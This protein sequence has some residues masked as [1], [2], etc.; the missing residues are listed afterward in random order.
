VSSA[1]LHVSYG[2]Q[3]HKVYVGRLD[4]IGLATHL[5]SPSGFIYFGGK[6]L[7]VPGLLVEKVLDLDLGGTSVL[8][9]WLVVEILLLSLSKVFSLQSFAFVVENVSST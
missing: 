8:N 1:V 4:I 7:K 3:R 2:A 9:F 5:L 6:W